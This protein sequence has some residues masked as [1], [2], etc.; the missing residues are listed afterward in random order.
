VTGAVPP[1]PLICEDQLG[2]SIFHGEAARAPR[3]PDPTT[4]F[5]KVQINLS[6]PVGATAVGTILTVLGGV[7]EAGLRFT[8]GKG[9][10]LRAGNADF[11]E[12]FLY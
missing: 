11:E 3:R 4:L 5:L 10:D 12:V 8:F 1:S 2:H 9:D 6:P 7:G